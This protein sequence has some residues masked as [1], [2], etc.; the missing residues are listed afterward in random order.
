MDCVDL[1][2]K[3]RNDKLTRIKIN[4]QNDQDNQKNGCY[5]ISTRLSRT[6][7]RT[8]ACFT[9]QLDTAVK[10]KEQQYASIIE[11]ILEGISILITLFL[12]AGQPLFSSQDNDSKLYRFI[13]GL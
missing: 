13:C 5:A 1:K 4:S 10:T 11:G 6:K 12:D 7:D 9:D 3:D 2:G 8:K